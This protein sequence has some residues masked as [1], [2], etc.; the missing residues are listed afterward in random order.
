MSEKIKTKA[1]YNY[2]IPGD[3]EIEELGQL[4]ILCTNGFVG[5]AKESYDEGAGA[6]L[7]IQGFNVT[8]GGFNLHNIKRVKRSF[9]EKNKKSRLVEG[10]LLTIQTGDIGVTTV[11][12]KELEGANCHALVISRL[13]KEI[14]HPYFYVQFFNSERGRRI[15]KTIETGSTM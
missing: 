11:V 8:E 7:Y 14:A 15:L 12:T 4:T 2:E 13:K 6:I 1:F 3:W 9:H 5:K 10:D